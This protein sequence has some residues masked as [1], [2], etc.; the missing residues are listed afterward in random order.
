MR[1]ALLLATLLAFLYFAIYNLIIIALLAMSFGEMSWLVRGRQPGRRSLSPSHPGISVLV[2]AYNEEPLIVST[3]ASLLVVD[4]EPLEVVVVDDGSTDGTFARLADAFDLVPLPLGGV[5]PIA[6][7]ELR[8]LFASRSAPGLRVVQKENSGRAGAL[9]AG[10]AVARH[11]LVAVVDA[12]GVVE[13]DAFMNA[14]RPFEEDPDD[15]VAVGGAIRVLDASR[16][17]A[18]GTVEARVGRRAIAATQ[19]IEYLR[20]FL[21]TRIAWSRMN[22]LLIVSGAFGVFRRDTLLAVG[23]FMPGSLGEDMEATVRLHHQLR[24]SW[25]DARVAFVPDAVCWTQAP[26]TVGGLRSQRMRW[27]VGLVETMR[28][29]QGMFGRKRYGAAG[30]LAFPF[31]ALFEALSP[32]IQIVGY[33][34]A[35]TLLVLDPSTWPYFVLLL[36]L[37]L[38]FGQVQ[39][40]MGLL[41]E[42]L[43]FR[44]YGRLGILKLL[45]WSLLECAWY[46]PLLVLWK[47]DATV[48]YIFGRRPSW[49]AIPRRAFDEA[50]ADAAVPLTR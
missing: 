23:G 1:D 47:A 37:T 33:A 9:N 48:R 16:V 31:V 4:Y 7:V 12:D 22:A 27:Q 24:P 49:G 50:P 46:Q 19:V 5:L 36:V 21:G 20:G 44:R 30:T 38:L 11:E 25:P 43:G 15:C 32:I 34:T 8:G 45:G 29:H 2:P 17:G 6:T 42:E 40:I 13:P 3:V 18:G 14:L 10:L 35:V 39:S 28:Q 41:V 26:D